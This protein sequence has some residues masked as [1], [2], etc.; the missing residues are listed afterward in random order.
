MSAEA[1]AESKTFVVNLF[2]ALNIG[3]GKSQASVVLAGG[4]KAWK[5]FEKCK[6]QGSA[7]G[8]L[9]SCNVVTSL[10]LSEIEG[11]ATAAVGALAQPGG[12]AYVAGALSLAANQ[13]EQSRPDATSVVLVVG[14]GRPLSESRTSDEAARIRDKARL[15]WMVVGGAHADKNPAAGSRILSADLASS[16]A[17][18]PYSDNVFQFD[19]YKDLLAL[20]TISDAISA[21]CPSVEGL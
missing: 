17:S 1:F 21:I 4:P 14:H 5:A 8:A 9:T 13:V 6:L 11:T 10:A 19:S 18:R 15:M 7:Q 12:P 16:W 2:K 3:P 20:P